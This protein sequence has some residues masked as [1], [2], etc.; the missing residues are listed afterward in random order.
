[1][2]ALKLAFRTLTRT[3]FVSAI[4]ILSL[5]LGIGANAAIFSLFDQMLLQALPVQEPDRL[6]NLS[7]PGPKPGSQS[8][9]Q[10]GDCTVVFSYAMFKDL[11]E[12][13]TSFS[14][15][16]AH[17]AFGTNLAAADQTVNGSGMLVSGS[18]FPILGV[19]PALGRLLGPQDDEVV[20]ENYVT[21]LGYDY[22]EN[23]LGL[24]PS[25]LNSTI[26]VNGQS[27]T[28]VGVAPRGFRG[29][30]LGVI[31][32]VYVPVTMRTV[33][34]RGGTG[35]TTA[36]TIGRTCSPDWHLE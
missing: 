13:S 8:C 9:S 7:N 1:M 12:V 35:G 11:E 15:V 20:G 31:P 29:T 14:G 26:I 33:M 22:W 16:A 5:A 18:Y 23:Q 3:P 24:D 21:V 17:R 6:V 2:S 28:V 27:M 32:D 19:R 36:E 25:V 34:S 10:A 4:A 30:T